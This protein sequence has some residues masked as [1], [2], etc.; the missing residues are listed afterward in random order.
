[1][2]SYLY[3][4]LSASFNMQ[5]PSRGDDIEVEQVYVVRLLI[6]SEMSGF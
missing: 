4:L 2:F 3:L 5:S 6:V 1:M